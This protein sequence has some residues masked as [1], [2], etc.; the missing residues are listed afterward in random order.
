VKLA[1]ESIVRR[2]GHLFDLLGSLQA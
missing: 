1:M 2:K